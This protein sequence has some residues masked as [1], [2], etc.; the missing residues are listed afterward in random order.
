LHRLRHGRPDAGAF[1][2]Q[3]TEQAGSRSPQRHGS[4][5]VGRNVCGGK[6]YR[7][8]YDQHDPRPE[9]YILMQCRRR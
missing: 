8:T 5:E 2:A 9:H 7:K 1:V 6:A 4:I 3:L